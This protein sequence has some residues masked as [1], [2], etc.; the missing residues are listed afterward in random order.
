MSLKPPAP[1]S[2]QK[3]L[4]SLLL[5]F[6]DLLLIA[7]SDKDG[8]NLLVSS[9]SQLDSKTESTHESPINESKISKESKESHIDGKIASIFSL[10]SEQASKLGLGTN[11]TI[12][13]F[14]DDY[15]V[16]S[17]NYF[18]LVIS[19][20]ATAEANE[21]VLLAIVPKVKLALEGIKTK[22]G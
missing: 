19:L 10:A 16:C 6:P 11:Q 1:E 9:R 13:A 5:R 21:G 3:T 17:V 8:V 7:A 20:V 14:Y 2:L 12:T 15:V 4:D 22:L 18:P